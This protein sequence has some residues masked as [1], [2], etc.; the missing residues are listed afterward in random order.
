MADARGI[1]ASLEQAARWAGGRL[2]GADREFVGVSSDTRTLQPG[3]L[4]VALTGPNHDGHDH[5]EAARQHG[6]AALL[7]AR[8]IDCDL[9]Q[10]EVA[11][12]RI[13]L[14]RLAAG[15][16]DSLDV[17]VVA[18]TGSNGKTT[19]KE[20]LAAILAQVGPT[21]ATRGN[22]NNDLGVPLTL[23]QLTPAHRFGVIEM[24]A[25]HPGEIAYLVELARPG[26][27]L[28]TN[29]AAAHLAGFGSLEGVARAK[30]EIYGGLA[31]DGVAVI[32]ADDRFAGAWREQAGARPVL[33]FG[34]AN[35]AD[36]GADF[37]ARA[38][39][40]QMKV[41]VPGGG[42]EVTLALP[43][44]HNAM[45][46]LAATAAATALGIAPEAIAA[47]LA[48]MRPVRGRLCP[49]A[50]TGG[51][52]LIDDSYNANPA[53]V[54][55]GISVLAALPG[56]RLLVLGDMGELGDDA[57]ELHREVGR[58]ARAADID[59]LY[60]TGEFSRETV[61][62]FGA[63]AAHFPDRGTLTAALRNEMSGETTLL[64]KGSRA[65][66]MDEVADALAAGEG[67]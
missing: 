57:A 1:Q 66:R 12:T 39:G 34:L 49:R 58:L 3:N 17:Q 13:A 11:D 56:R 67:C 14:G 30:G 64:I 44:Q 42:L 9:P 2:H 16:R 37:S 5:A 36:V 27:A 22:L 24:G 59:G 45:N 23:L 40:S 54:I 48:G 28:I 60:A 10:I 38:D 4:F 62:A 52:R 31:E 32:N 47:G 6:A 53:S 25:N 63:G 61:A 8:R 46:A 55:A 35:P 20:M 51:A 65:A 15:W 21:L 33:T 7:V 19:V 29:A 18:V 50:G 43:G 41:R 26:V